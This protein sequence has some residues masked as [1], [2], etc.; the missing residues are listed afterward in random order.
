MLIGT[1]GLAPPVCLGNGVNGL[2]SGQARG[3][4]SPLTPR[5]AARGPPFNPP[6]QGAGGR[7]DFWK[8]PFRQG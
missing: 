4:A 3:G 5:Q 1:A 2:P 6:A 8:K 7:A